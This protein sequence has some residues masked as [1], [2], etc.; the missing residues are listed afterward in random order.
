VASRR[1]WDE[2]TRLAC[3]TRVHG[4]VVIRRLPDNPQDIVV[5]DLDELHGV[6]AGE[7]K[8]L[9]L[10]ILFSDIRNFTTHSENNLP[11]DVVHMLNR[12][13]VAVADPVLNNNGFI[14][15][16][17]E[18]RRQSVPLKRLCLTEIFCLALQD[19]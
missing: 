2:F 5:L 8:E 12:H 17:Y 14:D 7:G 3:Q 4:D 15:K 9:E 13:F 16:Y 6:A 11:Y 10:A 1:G 18:S 19:Q